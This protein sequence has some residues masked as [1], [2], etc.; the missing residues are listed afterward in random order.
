[1]TIPVTPITLEDLT[2]AKVDGTGVFDTLMRAMTGHLEKEFQ[3]QRL[4]GAEYA[5]VYLGALQPVLQNAT[6][7]LLQKDEAAGKAALIDAQVRLTEKQIELAEAELLR[8]QN[9]AELVAAQVL[10]VKAETK[11]LGQEYLNLQAQECVLKAQYDLTMVQKLQTT[12]QTSLVQMKTTTEKAQTSGVGIEPDSVVG[13]QIALYTAQADGF[14]RDAEQ[15]AAKLLIDT[16]NVRRTTD[17]GTV[18][19]MTN[20]LSDANIGRA[21]TVMFTGIG[22]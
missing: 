12:A 4:R 19:D 17:S 13:K 6:M 2:Q 1:M 7:F 11:N 5:Q 22:A 16:W 8:E 3:L 21:I 15:K 9:N 20:M 18:A 14:K 10:K